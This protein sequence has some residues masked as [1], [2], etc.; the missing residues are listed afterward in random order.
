M[1]E[2][3]VL[4][5]S[6]NDWSVE[7]S[8]A[9]SISFWMTD[10][11]SFSECVCNVIT[12]FVAS[13]SPILSNYQYFTLVLNLVIQWSWVSSLLIGLVQRNSNLSAVKFFFNLKCIVKMDVAASYKSAG[14]VTVENSSPSFWPLIARRAAFFWQ[15]IG[16]ISNKFKGDA[17]FKVFK[18]LLPT[19]FNNYPII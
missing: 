15:A 6:S 2:W 7:T 18:P 9:R 11:C 12:N 8:L 10:D 3:R 1:S 17:A 14:G 4:F 19:S 13:C 16:L 5:F